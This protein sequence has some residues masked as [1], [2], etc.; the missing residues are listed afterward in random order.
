VL[1]VSLATLGACDSVYQTAINEVLALG[2]SIIVAAGNNG[3]NAS[4]YSPGSC[5]GVIT[6]GCCRQRTAGCRST[7]TP[8]RSSP[9]ARPGGLGSGADA[10]LTTLDSGIDFPLNDSSY[11]FQ[12]RHQYRR[13]ARD[14]RGEPDAI[15]EPRTQAS[16]GS[17][18]DEGSARAFPNAVA[19][20]R[21]VNCNTS[22]CGSGI[23]DARIATQSA[24]ALSRGE[25]QVVSGVC[26]RRRAWRSDGAVF[27]LS[28]GAT[29]APTQRSDISGW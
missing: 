27:D 16:L 11:S 26:L 19:A 25:P 15:R 28:S 5:N 4:N 12:F 13:R 22:A 21:T 2:V 24:K 9:S 20:G 29:S 23:V 18:I 6:V 8:A 1:N 17:R 3:A 10:V 14:G 7:P